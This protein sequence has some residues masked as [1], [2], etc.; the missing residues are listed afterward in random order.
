MADTKKK[1]QIL[2]R[3]PMPEQAPE[4]RRFNFKEVT[5]GYDME[6]A[7][8]EANRCLQCKKPL[9]VSGCPVEVDIKGFIRHV[10][11]RDIVS[12]YKA[13]LK[14]NS[15]PAVC[16]RVCPQENQC[17]GACILSKKGGA[18]AIGRLE[19]F[20]ADSIAVED[21]CLELSGREEC[22]MVRGEIK[23]ACIGSGPSSLTV[24][25]Y[26]STQ[27]IK[28][29]MYEALHEPGGVLVY[30]IP[31]FRLPKSIVHREIDALREYGVNIHTNWV[32]GRTVTVQDLFDRGYKAIFIGVGAGLP[33]FLK[34]PGENLIGVYSANEYLTRVNLGRAYTFPDHDT[35][36]HS[37]AQC[38]GIGRRQRGHGRGPHRPCGL[39]RKTCISS[40]AVP[41]RKCLR[42]GRRS[43]MPWTRA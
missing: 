32:G 33:W 6:M 8:A 15:L 1:K 28:V 5:L 40:I 22:P 11:Q 3:T 25:A 29:S 41:R 10:Q 27:G 20:V 14:T 2:P 35:P 34:L 37:G 31:E 7:V 13:I 39:V 19:R 43:T 30:G 12:A 16:G 18:V 9:C 23:V 36:G 26:L 4:E 21:A 38:H 24:A 17:E 42:V